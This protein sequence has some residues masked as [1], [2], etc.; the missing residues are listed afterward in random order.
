MVVISAADL[1]LL[2]SFCLV[3]STEEVLFLLLDFGGDQDHVT[4]GLDLG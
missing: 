1:D 4:L 2:L 3:T